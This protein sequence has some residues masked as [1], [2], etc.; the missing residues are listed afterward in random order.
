MNEAKFTDGPIELFGIGDK[1]KRL[2][3]AKDNMSLLTVVI[4]YDDDGEPTYFGAVENPADAHLFQAA[5]DMYEALRAALCDDP[6]WRRLAVDA[7][8]KADD[9]VEKANA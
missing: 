1:I 7:L 5:H 6:D 8:A 2:C 3:P 9:R 4:E